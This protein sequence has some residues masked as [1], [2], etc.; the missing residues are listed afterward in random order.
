MKKIALIIIGFGLITM[1]IL[2]QEN[3]T[4]FRK[5]LSLGIKAG[6]NYSNVYDE[7]GEDFIADG[8]FG[9]VYGVFLAIPI[10]RFLG[11]QPEI[12]LSQKGFKSSGK[13]LGSSY[14]LTR[15]T[16]YADVPILFAF[17]PSEFIT[18]VAGPQFSYLLNQ[19]DSFKNGTTT[20]E[21]ENTFQNDDVRKNIF[22]FTGGVDITMKHFVIGAR[23]GWDVQNNN[24]NGVS[25][26]PRYKNV[27]YQATIGYRFYTKNK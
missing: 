25:T 24:P 16:T 23:A 8:K 26:T 13:L 14:N 22:C 20:I 7:Q 11:V 3:T 17:K 6:L 19:K 12:L 18:L 1:K 27:W 5:K 4:D 9:G 15:T 2:A 21:Q 10:G